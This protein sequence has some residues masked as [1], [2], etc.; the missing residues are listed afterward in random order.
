[1][2]ACSGDSSS[3]SVVKGGGLDEIGDESKVGGEGRTKG[4][5][6]KMAEERMRC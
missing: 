1:M 5:E 6:K 4:E 2:T 3:R